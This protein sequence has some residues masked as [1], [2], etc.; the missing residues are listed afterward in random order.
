[1]PPFFICDLNLQGEHDA[2]EVCVEWGLAPIKIFTV[3]L[4]PGIY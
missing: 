1:M 4:L 3:L 2:I